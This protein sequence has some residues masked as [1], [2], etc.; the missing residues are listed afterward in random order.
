MSAKCILLGLGVLVGLEAWALPGLDPRIA[1]E[2]APTELSCIELGDTRAMVQAMRSSKV[3]PRVFFELGIVAPWLEGSGYAL[4]FE[5][6]VDATPER[7]ISIALEEGGTLT[8]KLAFSDLS[9]R[10]AVNLDLARG[11]GVDIPDAAKRISNESL[12]KEWQRHLGMDRLRALGA[13]LRREF[14]ELDPAWVDATIKDRSD[15]MLSQFLGLS[16]HP[17]EGEVS[18]A[19]SRKLEF[20]RQLWR[21]N[22][23][24]SAGQPGAGESCKKWIT[25]SIRFLLQAARRQRR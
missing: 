9:S 17:T 23:A 22:R 2:S 5:G 6:K 10:Y 3:Q 11:R 1:R 25:Q 8:G 19:I 7:A 21:L 15:L 12:T 4:F 20:S 18:R 13:T 14:A 24:I 16:P